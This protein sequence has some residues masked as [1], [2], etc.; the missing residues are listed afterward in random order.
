MHGIW[1]ALFHINTGLLHWC[2]AILL[3]AL[4][5]WRVGIPR[6]RLPML[7][8]FDLNIEVNVRTYTV[9]AIV[10]GELY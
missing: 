6:L 7:S 10:Q 5:M 2:T 3:I 1:Q 9:N 8:R 4:V